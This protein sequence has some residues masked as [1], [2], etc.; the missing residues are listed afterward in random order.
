MHFSVGVLQSSQEGENA[1][2]HARQVASRRCGVMALLCGQDCP[3]ELLSARGHCEIVVL[4]SA[5]L[6]TKFAQT[7][8]K[9]RNM[10]GYNSSKSS[11]FD[12][13]LYLLSAP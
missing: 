9:N 8:R 11:D 4:L 3:S 5:Q 2:M 7:G 12:T 13:T 1:S 6:A 10:L